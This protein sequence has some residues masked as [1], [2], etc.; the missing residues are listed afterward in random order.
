MCCFYDQISVYSDNVLSPH[1]RVQTG[2]D[3]QGVPTVGTYRSCVRI[4]LRPHFGD[5]VHRHDV[6]SIWNLIT[7]LGIHRA[8]FVLRQKGNYIYFIFSSFLILTSVQN[9]EL[10][11]R[12][13][14]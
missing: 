4:L 10:Q 7:H 12:I 8:E 14:R 11:L 5:P 13:I 2:A 1:Y 6:P 3:L 9:A